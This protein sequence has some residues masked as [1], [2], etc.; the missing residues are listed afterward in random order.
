[1]PEYTITSTSIPSLVL[2]PTELDVDDLVGE[3]AAA[4]VSSHPC[5]GATESHPASSSSQTTPATIG[6][7]TSVNI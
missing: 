1:M 3:D 5:P 2:N 6:A 4:A 7:I